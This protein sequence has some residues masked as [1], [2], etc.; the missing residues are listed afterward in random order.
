M[1][2]E[3][4][5][6]EIGVGDVQG[7]RAFYEA[8]FGWAFTPGPSGDGFVIEARGT[9][10]GMHGGDPGSSPYLFFAVDDIDLAV[11]RVRE[12][13]G[14]VDDADDGSDEDSERRFGRFR[15]CRDDQGSV[16]G[17]H[18]RPPA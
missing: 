10:G 11:E 7:G 16:F 12:L 17:L 5:F 13:G 9:P 6:F 18:E 2:G 4:S 1:A 14:T 3:L 15:L 8:L